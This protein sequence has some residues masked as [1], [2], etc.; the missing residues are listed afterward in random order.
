M[1]R[2][3][4]VCCCLAVAAPRLAEAQLNESPGSAFAIGLGATVLPV[5]GG[6]AL[7]ERPPGAVILI[8]SGLVLGPSIGY[9][10]GGMGGHAFRGFLLRTGLAVATLAASVAICGD[11]AQHDDSYDDALIALGVGGVI[12]ASL[13]GIDVGRTPENVRAHQASRR[14]AAV[15]LVPVGASGRR[16]FAAVIAVP[17]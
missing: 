11:C 5:A 1:G 10:S 15:R 7:L 6:L 9:W 13:A 2:M 16:G 12:I 14:G 4:V 8:G 17:L 3:L